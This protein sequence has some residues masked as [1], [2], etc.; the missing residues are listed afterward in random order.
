[1]SKNL[2]AFLY[3]INDIR[4][5][6]RD[7]PVPNENQLLIKVHT[8]GLCGS[9]VHFWKKGAIGSFHVKDPLVLGHEPSGI[10]AGLGSKVKNFSIGDR[11][12][13]EP[14]NPCRACHLCKSGR[15]NLCHDM[16]FLGAP[17]I[18][19]SLS[20][21][22]VHNADLC[23]KL[24]ENVTFDEAAL[25]EPLAVAVHACQRAEL[26]I[27]ENVLVQGAGSIGT[28]CMMTAKAMGVGQI[29][30]TDLEERKLDI[31]KT[32][33]AD[34]SVCAKNKSV[35]EVK[36]LVTKCL[37]CEPDVTIECTGA[38]SCLESSILVTTQ[39]KLSENILAGFLFWATRSGGRIIMVGLGNPR[40]E[41][42]MIDCCLREVDI[43]GSF[44]FANDYPTALNLLASKKVD[45]SR[46]TSAHYKLEEVVEA[47]ERTQKGDVMK[48]FVQC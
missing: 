1:M 22:M 4:L 39:N 45:I 23:F 15:Y 18:H 47:L 36:Q 7:V 11:V 43:R 42:P 29:V 34:H 32:L 17:S 31:A 25:L 48:V 35:E 40:V 30:I 3:G 27:G 10:V 2:S 33:G 9:D 13:L 37:K 16:R 46:F 28:L 20:R 6:N 26:R 21:Y 38:R 19:G 24:P 14:G 8:V 44:R 5:K 12:A 41:L